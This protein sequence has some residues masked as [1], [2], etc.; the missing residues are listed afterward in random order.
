MID[1]GAGGR[2][3]SAEIRV[4]PEEVGQQ[5]LKAGFI[6]VRHFEDFPNNFLVIAYE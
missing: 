1:L 5:L 6:N 2:G 4:T 3:P